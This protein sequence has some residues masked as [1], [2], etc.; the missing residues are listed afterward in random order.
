MDLN[1]LG[2]ACARLSE[3]GES[4]RQEKSFQP[5]RLTQVGIQLSHVLGRSA[6]TQEA[7]D[8]A[9]I[10]SSLHGRDTIGRA[11]KQYLRE[12]SSH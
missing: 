11:I 5:K 8:V 3:C 9:A 1:S 6:S 2:L 12:S 4:P 7:E 10:A